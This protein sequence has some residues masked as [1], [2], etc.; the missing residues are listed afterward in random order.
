MWLVEE[1][2]VDKFRDAIAE[3]MGQPLA[4]GVSTLPPQ[5]TGIPSFGPVYRGVVV[6][7]PHGLVAL[8][9]GLAARERTLAHSRRQCPRKGGGMPAC[10]N[11]SQA[12]NPSKD[13][14]NIAVFKQH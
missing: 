6:A 14:H 7:H 1:W 11:A 12:G 9:Q 3:Q 4:E 2:G 5:R 13:S 8:A 10:R